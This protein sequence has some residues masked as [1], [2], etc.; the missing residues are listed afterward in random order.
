MSSGIYVLKPIGKEQIYLGY[1]DNL[2][3]RFYSH[4]IN[5]LSGNHSQAVQ[6]L[7]DENHSFEWLPLVVEH[8]K[9]NK[10]LSILEKVLISYFFNTTPRM[11]LNKVN[12][13]YS[14]SIL[15]SAEERQ[16]FMK[17]VSMILSITYKK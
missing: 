1:S 8:R 16:M 9:S 15:K 6:A 3:S 14:P 13:R 12:Y 11:L 17:L 10:R 7:F 2:K 5:F 4:K